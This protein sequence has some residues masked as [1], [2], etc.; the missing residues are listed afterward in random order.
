[1]FVHLFRR[2]RLSNDC[3]SRTFLRPEY[4]HMRMLMKS[5]M[6]V[7]AVLS[8]APAP[9]LA[10]LPD[11]D[12]SCTVFEGVT[13]PCSTQCSKPWGGAPITCGE[14][15]ASYGYQYPDNTCAPG[16]VAPEASCDTVTQDSLEGSEEACREPEED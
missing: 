11:C 2:H 16:F 1:M 12:W 9:A 8:L 10:R 15:M 13:T 3:S 4:T 6:A 14:W 5:L 7:W